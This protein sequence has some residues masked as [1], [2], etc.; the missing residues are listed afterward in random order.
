MS[1]VMAE[2]MG[3]EQAEMMGIVPA[4]PLHEIVDI[5]PRKRC[6]SK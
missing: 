3:V 6:N 2:M 5:Q 1:E 4:A